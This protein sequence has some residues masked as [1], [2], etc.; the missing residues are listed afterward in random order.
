M[1]KSYKTYKDLTK[2]P[3]Y[4]NVYKGAEYYSF[5]EDVDKQAKADKWFELF[6]TNQKDRPLTKNEFDEF[7]N[8]SKEL[9]WEDFG[10]GGVVTYKD[11]YNT[12]YGY[13]K[14]ESH[15]LEE[16]SKDTG[17]SMKGLQQIYNKGI[18]AYKTNPSSVRPNVKSKEQWAM[19]RVYSAVMGGKAS[20][21]D[22]HELKME[23]GGQITSY[24]EFYDNL[25]I[26]D[27]SKYIGQKFND[28]FPFLSRG[29][30]TPFYF[31]LKVEQYE[32][33][34]ERL[35]KDNYTT[36]SKKTRDLNKLEAHKKHIDKY[37]YLSRFYLDSK[38]TIIKFMKNDEME[39]GGSNSDIRF[40]E[41][42]EV[43]SEL[44]LII[45]GVKNENK[46]KGN[47]KKIFDL[48]EENITFYNPYGTSFE[49]LR[50]NN[51]YITITPRPESHT[52][53]KISKLKDV[54]IIGNAYIGEPIEFYVR[55]YADGTKETFSIEEYEKNIYPSIEKKNK[56]NNG[57]KVSEKEQM[58]DFINHLKSSLPFLDKEG[59]SSVKKLIE[60]SE[61]AI[62]YID[63]ED[64]SIEEAND[65][66]KKSPLLIELNQVNKTIYHTG[67]PMFRESILKQGLIPQGKSESWLSDTPIEGEVIFA[68]NSSDIADAWQ[69]GYDDDI[70]EI[71]TTQLNNQWYFD[72]N[73]ASYEDNDRIITFEPIPSSAIKLI[74]QGSGE[75]YKKG[76]MINEKTIR[77]NVE[78]L[79]EQFYELNKEMDIPISV[80]KQYEKTGKV[81][82][83]FLNDLTSET[84]ESN[85]VETNPISV[86]L[87]PIK[88]MNEGGKVISDNINAKLESMGFVRNPHNY[89]MGKN[90][91]EN[92]YIQPFYDK[93]KGI[94][95]IRGVKKFKTSL[96]GN[97]VGVQFDFDNEKDFFAKINELSSESSEHFDDG[98]KVSQKEQTQDFINQLKSSLPYL[99][100]EGKA[101]VKELIESLE[102]AIQYMDDEDISIEESKDEIKKSPLPYLMTLDEYKES[103]IIELLKEYQKFVRKHQKSLLANDYSSSDYMTLEEYLELGKESPLYGEKDIMGRPQTK[104]VE[105]VITKYFMDRKTQW[106]KN[107]EEYEPATKEVINQNKKYR[108]RLLK[109]F[110]LNK[111]R[112]I[113]VDSD[114]FKS[115][116]RAIKNAMDDKVYYDLLKSGELSIERLEEITSSVGVRITKD[117]LKGDKTAEFKEYISKTK[118]PQKSYEAIVEFAKKV[119]ADL[120]PIMDE[121]YE[122]EFNRYET[123]LKESVGKIMKSKNMVYVPNMIF[124]VQIKPMGNYEQEI[125]GLRPEYKEKLKDVVSQE[126]EEL[127]WNIIKAMANALLYFKI[128]LKSFERIYIRRGAKGFE[129]AYKMIFE[130]GSSLVV[131]TTGI[132]AGGYNIQRFHYRYITSIT[133]MTLPNGQK[134]KDDSHFK[135]YRITTFEDG[136]WM[137]SKFAE[138]GK[139]TQ[140][141]IQSMRN[142]INSPN[143]NPKLKESFEKVLRKFGV[144]VAQTDIS[145]FPKGK[146]VDTYDFAGYEY[147]RNINEE[148]GVHFLLTGEY[149]LVSKAI[150]EKDYS[151]WM[152]YNYLGRINISFQSCL[153]WLREASDYFS[154]TLPVPI[155][156]VHTPKAKDGRSYAQWYS[157]S[158]EYKIEAEGKIGRPITFEFNDRWYYN[159]IGMVANGDADGG[160]GTRY[161][162]KK[163][164]LLV[165]EYMETS[166]HFNTLIHEF[167]HCLDFQTQLVE[168]IEKYQENKDKIEPNLNFGELERALYLKQIQEKPKEVT[169][170]IG[171]HFDTFVNAL[172]RI[173][174]ACAGGHIPVT[175]L[176]EQQA[177]DVQTAL[178]GTYGDLLLAQR[179][180]RE[181]ERKNLQ[182]A[183]EIRDNKR[184]TWQGYWNREMKNFLIENAIQ[185]GLKNKLETNTKEGYTLPEIIEL[186]NMLSNYM[187]KDF[188]AFS[189]VNP[190]KSQERADAIKEMRIEAN[191]IINNHYDNIKKGFEYGYQPKNEVEMY[192]FENCRL[193]D[194]RDYKSWKE[195]SKQM[196]TNFR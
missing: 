46:Y 47:Y 128:P 42:G 91:D 121:V 102:S 4:K 31:R 88:K 12:K 147:M 171:T 140:F 5:S 9:A 53:E 30:K 190:S 134:T 122:K 119:K 174:R 8:L 193:K 160:W 3:N 75:E 138:G 106:G 183:N 33:E 175:Q 107:P 137:T 124:M 45:K 117:T 152:F 17:V 157:V 192:L 85:W 178:S 116:K 159:E 66:I 83:E 109:H 110:P 173:L 118:V 27:G 149:Q 34:V 74:H 170:V 108:E 97:S 187:L 126:V 73:F 167:A 114:E 92:T 26:E 6:R 39:K 141:E 196:L 59:K 125:I 120:K 81:P 18:G 111:Y 1:K 82:R 129:G 189:S 154:Y 41:G 35:K 158:N 7:M 136:G 79:E 93:N 60:S 113:R 168:N 179:E 32:G 77:V 87:T 163:T 57:G 40:N 100:K 43:G 145:N 25:E 19:A 162:E 56:M 165:P 146:F 143:P 127:T 164:G 101:S 14:N 65:E 156:L 24:T 181:Q 194:Y 105:E 135:E 20:K 16:I 51:F 55:T 29:R 21:I 195:C 50:G 11:K 37:K 166:F 188:Y 191:R 15:T 90:I 10:K 63:D 23:K 13:K 69:S 176:F 184:F 182:V 64:V 99:D 58:Q 84:G 186:D 104:S 89:L 130:D 38:G 185:E 150:F 144:D 76:G 72:P 49:E 52:I 2:I 172:I 169:Q 70:Y 61:S 36:P 22:S 142:Y 44:S 153:E 123:L 48:I 86:S 98:G 78:Y 180:R 80:Y 155:Y 68:V 148:A 62:Q 54:E 112:R 161:K 94:Y 103:G 139:I 71:E 67:N 132:G 95:K 151:M 28:V 131:N 133:D 177:I 115:N 96:G